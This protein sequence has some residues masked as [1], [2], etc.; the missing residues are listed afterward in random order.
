MLVYGK[1][2]WFY[3]SDGKTWVNK[4]EGMESLKKKPSRT[5]L[6]ESKWIVTCNKNKK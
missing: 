3:Y 4:K 5:K 2:I 1:H 6:E